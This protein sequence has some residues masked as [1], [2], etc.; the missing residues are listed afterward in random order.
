MAVDRLV[1]IDLSRLEIGLPLRYDVV[2]EKGSLLAPAGTRF[3]E[4]L[5]T[6]WSQQGISII[7]IKLGDELLSASDSLLLPYDLDVLTRLENNLEKA[8]TAVFTAA[9]RL[10]DQQTVNCA[11][12]QE[13]TSQLLTDIQKDSAIALF[14]LFNGHQRPPTLNDQL[15]ADRCSQLSLLSMVVAVESGLDDQEC[16]QVGI[17]GLL[18]DI[19]LMC[20]PTNLNSDEEHDLY[21]QHSLK[22]AGMAEG[23]QGIDPRIC[24]AIAQVHESSLGNGFP[25]GLHGT[26]IMPLARIIHLADAYL[27]L[28]SPHQPELFPNGCNLHPADSLGY[29]MYHAARGEFERDKVK[30]LIDATSLYPVGSSVQLSD[31]STATVY[32]SSREVPS[33]PVVQLEDRSLINLHASQLTVLGPNRQPQRNTALKVSR[34]AEVLWA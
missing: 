12:F 14:C 27:T 30:A 26:R 9:S 1:P 25:R 7:Q 32:R 23:I 17:A 4:K 21:H 16:R 33:L 5:R 24:A 28:T 22:S 3:T 19:S 20:L 29:I 15:V 8:K 34:I 6:L 18:H 2:D 13:L 10:A 11:G 31:A